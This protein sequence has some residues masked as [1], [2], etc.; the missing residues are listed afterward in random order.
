MNYVHWMQKMNKFDVSMKKIYQEWVLL[1]IIYTYLQL[2]GSQYSL[3][4][5]IC[6][7]LN[8]RMHHNGVMAGR[9]LYSD[10]KWRGLN[11]GFKK[12]NDCNQYELMLSLHEFSW[13]ANKLKRR[14]QYCLVKAQRRE[15]KSLRKMRGTKDMCIDVH[16]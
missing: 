12:E 13:W 4:A 11:K 3:F 1:N 15:Q 14:I 6:R 9:V 10:D 2:K 7:S 5:T 8:C 16:N